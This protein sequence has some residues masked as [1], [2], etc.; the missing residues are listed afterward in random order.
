MID[1]WGGDDETITGQPRAR[2]KHRP[3]QLENVRVEENAGILT[4]WCRGG[5]ECSHRLAA[6]L[7]V[8]ITSSDN[9]RTS[10]CDNT[11]RVF[12]SAIAASEGMIMSTPILHQ[13]ISAL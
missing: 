3:G 7:D 2:S 9:H 4:S 13:R 1:F 8:G 10:S 11:S 12:E 6:D 5:N